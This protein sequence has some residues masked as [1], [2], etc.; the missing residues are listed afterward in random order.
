M[1]PLNWGKWR[2]FV[3]LRRAVSA[4]CSVKQEWRW[5]V[6][7]CVD[8]Y[9]K[10]GWL[11]RK[12]EWSKW[13]RRMR[14][15]SFSVWF[16]PLIGKWGKLMRPGEGRRQRRKTCRKKKIRA[17][18]QWTIKALELTEG[19]RLCAVCSCGDSWGLMES[20]WDPMHGSVPGFSAHGIL[21]ARI[22]EWVTVS[23]SRGS[24]QSRE[25]LIMVTIHSAVL[26]DIPAEVSIS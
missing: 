19:G 7:I 21:Q 11:S 25:S 22:L 14:D 24:S 16:Y 17:R 18:V 1:R 9:F 6:R 10:G 26:G 23:S 13:L 8:N 5:S 12:Q 4:E 20:L 15:P 3:T 2:S